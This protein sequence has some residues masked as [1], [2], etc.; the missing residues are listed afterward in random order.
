MECQISR[1][2]DTLDDPR[3]VLVGSAR[4]HFRIPL[5]QRLQQ[6]G[7]QPIAVG[8]DDLKKV[9]A[10]QGFVYHRYPLMRRMSPMADRVAI[11]RL[12]E[13]FED[14]QPSVVHSFNTKPNFLATIAAQV[15]PQ[16]KVVRT[17]TGMGPLFTR[18]GVLATVG[19]FAYRYV[20]RRLRD[21]VDVHV[22][23]NQDDYDYFFRH[24]LVRKKS[25]EL[26]RGSGI[27]LKAFPRSPYDAEAKRNLR[28]SLGLPEG[29]TVLM[30]S[31]FIRSKGV[32]EYSH[33]AEMVH[34]KDPTIQFLLVGEPVRMGD[35][36]LATDC[37]VPS[38]SVHCLGPRQDIAR[39]L[40][41]C[42]VCALPSY[43][44]GLPR[45]LLEAG[46][47]G[48][49]LITTDVPGCREVVEDGVNG[50]LVPPRNGRCLADAVLDLV[51][52]PER[53]HSMARASHKRIAT[54]FSIQY[55]AERYAEIYRNLLSGVVKP[56]VAAA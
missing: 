7:F 42:D 18:Q 44:E 6:F 28:K 21:R 19:Q 13:I 17:V 31:R 52:N 48:L 38:S 32:A 45:V 2:S 8:Q 20:Q 22:F 49:P 16:A 41:A 9:F 27:D 39:L 15:V 25:V 50:I 3:V 12:R 23:Q 1:K 46:A 47:V 30:I 10:D 36:K 53:C 5:M 54:H 34:K 37:V 35:G 4:V 56:Y 43:R 55:V 26:V 24:R 11:K 29:F 40:A 14:I 51:A 33:A